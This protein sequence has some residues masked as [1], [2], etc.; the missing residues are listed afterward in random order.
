MRT[1]LPNNQVNIDYRLIIQ[2]Y[3][4][5]LVKEL[6]DEIISI[7]IEGSYAKGDAKDTSDFD[8]FIIIDN[9]TICKLKILGKHTKTISEKYNGV[10]VNP[11]CIGLQ[12]FEQAEFENWSMKSIIALN[13]VLLYGQDMSAQ[14]TDKKYL[15]EYYRKNM[16]ELLMGI[17]HYISLDKP[18]ERITYSNVYAFILK[19]LLYNMRVERYCKTGKY[20]QSYKDLRAAYLDECTLFVDYSLEPEKFIKDIQDKKDDTLEKMHTLITKMIYE[21]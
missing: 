1:E 17:R 6:K 2:E 21:C 14:V 19:P 12:E 5:A 11:Q 3:V 20:P 13:S 8:I 7:Y 16:V 18:S 10:K 4:N 15:T 9:L